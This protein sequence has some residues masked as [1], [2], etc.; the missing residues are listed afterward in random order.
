[1][2]LKNQQS[3]E[4]SDDIEV[5]YEK[6]RGSSTA[7]GNLL[8]LLQMLTM[9]VV[10]IPFCTHCFSIVAAPREPSPQSILIQESPEA[11]VIEESPPGLLIADSFSLRSHEFAEAPI[12]PIVIAPIDE[13]KFLVP[14][15]H[16]I[17]N[18]D[19]SV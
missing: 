4:Q 18:Y 14:N 7:T 16:F 6:Q 8:I 15:A 5:I 2:F 10:L 17:Y 9:K 3:E 11:I 1:M 12:T 13:C 19:I